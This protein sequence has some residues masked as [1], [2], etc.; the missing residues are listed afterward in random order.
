MEIC[1]FHNISVPS[2]IGEKHLVQISV[3]QYMKLSNCR[4]GKKI[5]KS[6]PKFLRIE[7]PDNLIIMYTKFIDES[8]K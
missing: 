2:A 5:L 3:K 4:L 1:S 8:K 6:N 7:I